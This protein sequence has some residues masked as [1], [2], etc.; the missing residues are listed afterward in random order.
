MTSPPSTLIRKR[1]DGSEDR[2]CG[3]CGAEYHIPP[4]ERCNPLSRDLY[5]KCLRAE[6]Q[7]VFDEKE[8]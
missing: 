8:G 3:T 7:R 1:E 6:Q 2:R 4:Y 5:T